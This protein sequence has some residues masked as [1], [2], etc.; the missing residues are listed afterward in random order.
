VQSYKLG[1]AAIKMQSRLLFFW[2]VVKA[3]GVQINGSFLYGAVN[4][5]ALYLAFFLG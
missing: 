5:F 2:V 4:N 1:L 3:L